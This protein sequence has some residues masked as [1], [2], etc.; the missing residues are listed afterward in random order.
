VT[1]GQP[2][3][4]I[5]IS[6]GTDFNCLALSR[7][8]V[9]DINTSSTNQ[10]TVIIL[11]GGLTATVLTNQALRCDPAGPR[12]TYTGVRHGGNV[13]DNVVLKM[14]DWLGRG[15]WFIDTDGT[16]STT[17]DGGTYLCLTARH[18]VIY[19]IPLDQIHAWPDVADHP[20]QCH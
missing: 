5:P 16:I 13:P 20:A 8:V 6:T 12:W 17:P 15:S 4:A 7:Y 14:P 10:D 11:P 3:T 1:P 2:N 19:N 9:D 18:P